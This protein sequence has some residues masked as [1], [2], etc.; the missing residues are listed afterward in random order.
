MS[1][2]SIYWL[3]QLD[4]INCF[5][6]VLAWVGAIL[7]VIAGLCHFIVISIGD[8]PKTPIKV[9]KISLGVFFTFG[10]ISTFIP[11]TKTMAAIYV[12]PKIL[13]GDTLETVSKDGADIYKLGINRLKEILEEK[14]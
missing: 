8:E 7:T 3:F 9:I 11:S 4:S 5:F 14:K 1:A 10:L 2:W 13:K 6:G 12:L